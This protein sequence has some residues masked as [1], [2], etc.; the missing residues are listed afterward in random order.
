MSD[1][2]E[3]A[4]E[5]HCFLTAQRVSYAI[6]G[7]L[8]VQRWGEPRF[9]RDVDVTVVVPFEQAASFIGAVVKNFA[10][11]IEDAAAFARRSRVI[12]VSAAN[13]C[14]VDISLGLPGYEDEVIR[15]AVDFELEPG[16]IVRLCAP[17][18]LVIHKAV[19]GRPRDLEDIRGI[20]H[21]R[22][23]SLDTD[24]IRLWLGRF[25]EILG[26]SAPSDRFT[27]IWRRWEADNRRKK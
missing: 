14:Q 7:G 15:R 1:P 5:V 11:R 3:A 12:L 2:L 23:E 19:A 25:S 16:K 20:V 8:A 10:P 26:D 6:I 21:R 9:T 17:E 22:G 24:L 18:D 4:W 27:Q 13:G